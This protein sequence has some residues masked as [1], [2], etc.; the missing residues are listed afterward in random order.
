[1]FI[2]R[3][4]FGNRND[5]A[6]MNALH[7]AQIRRAFVQAGFLPLPPSVQVLE[8]ATQ[9]YLRGVDIPT[10]DNQTTQVS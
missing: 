4:E 9:D 10:L 5:E 6:L 7:N 2:Y 8:D 1:M 3:N